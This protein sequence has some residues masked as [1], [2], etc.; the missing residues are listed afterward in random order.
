MLDPI[1]RR[2]LMSYYLDE[3]ALATYQD[4]AI[5]FGAAAVAYTLFTPEL[6]KEFADGIALRIEGARAE[7]PTSRIGIPAELQAATQAVAAGEESPQ[8]AFDAALKRLNLGAQSDA[9]IEGFFLNESAME[10]DFEPPEEF[11]AL[12]EL[13]YGVIVTHHQFPGDDWATPIVFV[14]VLT[15]RTE[16]G[17]TASRGEYSQT[18]IKSPGTAASL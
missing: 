3:L 5:G 12:E 14:F 9:F 1:S 10:G 4:P 11:V 18:S 16:R 8:V 15:E 17:T 13:R 2:A 7:R 6:E